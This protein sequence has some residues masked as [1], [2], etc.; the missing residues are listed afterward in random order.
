VVE[1]T[2]ETTVLRGRHKGHRSVE[3]VVYVGSLEFEPA[4][5]PELLRR[6]RLYWDIKGGLHQRLD[7]SGAE[8]AAPATAT[9]SSS[10]ASCAAPP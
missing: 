3:K 7:V 8:D 2:R 5:A 4:R 10:C 9:R 1:V 6:I